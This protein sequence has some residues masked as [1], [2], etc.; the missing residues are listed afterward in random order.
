[1]PNEIS[2]PSE[3]MELVNGF[4]N[5]RIILSAYELELFT[6]LKEQPVISG[7]VAAR[8][9]MDPRALD[10]FMNALV[11]IGLLRKTNGQFSNTDFS[12]KFLVK[13]E[14]SYL[15]GLAHQVHL[16]KTWST[17]TDAI[18]AGTSVAVEEPI[19]LRSDEWL[20]SFIAA[21]HSRGVPQSKEVADLID[22]SGI[23]SILDVGGGSGAFTFEFLRRCKNGRAVIFDLPGSGPDHKEIHT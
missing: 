21:M 9:R 12:S 6:Q 8:L 16:W 3:F 15:S 19:A 10:R 7:E 11:A 14:P 20:D 1:M 22:F 13:G 2:L 18:K 23:E 4:R 5:S 17:L